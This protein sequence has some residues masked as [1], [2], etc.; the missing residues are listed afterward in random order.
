MNILLPVDLS[1]ASMN[2]AQYAVGLCQQYAGSKIYL[3]HCVEIEE[4]AGS[5]AVA[6][7]MADNKLLLQDFQNILFSLAPVSLESEI[8]VG[9]F[10][11][12]VAISLDNHDIDLVLIGVNDGGAVKRNYV[13]SH[14]MA[15]V[16]LERC[17]VLIIPPNVDFA[18]VKQLAVAMKLET[19]E[20]HLPASVLSAAV[21]LFEAT[22]HV[23]SVDPDYYIS[24]TERQQ[25]DKEKIAA[26]LGVPAEFSFLRLYDVD[27]ALELFVKDRNIDILVTIPHAGGLMGL[28]P[29]RSH[30][31][32]LSYDS[33]VPVLAIPSNLG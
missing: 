32:K 18:P 30:T 6:K 16:E 20:K 3:M 26:L 4:D 11:D 17:P 24:L 15:V 12:A 28:T 23:V 22:L 5:D 31:A 1:E 10:A 21:K 27:E 9:A 25:A 29:S 33:K 19:A 13:E 2:A 8:Q 14:A 7:L